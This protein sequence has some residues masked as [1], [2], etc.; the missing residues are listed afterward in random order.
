M[1]VDQMKGISVTEE[2]KKRKKI[3]VVLKQ[4]KVVTKTLNNEL[5]SWY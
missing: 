3:V 1:T 4:N 5:S 2:R